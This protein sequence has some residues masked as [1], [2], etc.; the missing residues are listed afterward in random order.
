MPQPAHD[1]TRLLIQL[2]QGDTEAAAQLLPLL[3]DELRRVAQ[4]NLRNERL[5]HTLQATA[6]VHEAYLRLVRTADRTWENRAHFIGVAAHIMR[7][8]LVDYARS[9]DAGK[10]IPHRKRV[11][12]AEEVLVSPDRSEELIALDEALTR[13]AALSPRQSR[14]VE[15]RYFGGLSV[16]QTAEVLGVSEKTVKRDWTVARTWLHAEMASR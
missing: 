15:L 13:L 3:Y 4:R 10:R 11:S 8:V 5:N 14:V 9:W 12:L 16:E 2:G 7:T 1:V 6:L